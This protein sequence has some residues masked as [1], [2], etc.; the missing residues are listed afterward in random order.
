MSPFSSPLTLPWPPLTPN[1]F[2]FYRRFLFWILVS[3]LCLSKASPVLNSCQL[4][5]VSF[6][7]FIY[8]LRKIYRI[9]S[10]IIEIC[11]WVHVG[12]CVVITIE[13]YYEKVLFQ[14]KFLYLFS[15]I[16]NS[17][18]GTTNFACSYAMSY[19]WNI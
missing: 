16:T 8:F 3:T 18:L 13:L 15:Q 6:K 17:F 4:R 19:Q 9:L 14:H 5:L 2:I 1:F 10:N 12:K 11:I 7:F